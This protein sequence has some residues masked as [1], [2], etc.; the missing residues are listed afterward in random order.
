MLESHGNSL[1]ISLWSEVWLWELLVSGLRRTLLLPLGQERRR[2]SDL[3]IKFT[4][5]G[6]KCNIV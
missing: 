5:G 2:P 4:E 3:K 1:Y 6:V